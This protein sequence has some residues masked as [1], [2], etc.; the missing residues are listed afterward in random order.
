MLT[1]KELG[2][3]FGVSRERVRQLEVNIK[4]KLV[5]YFRTLS[6]TAKARAKV[7]A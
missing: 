6:K 1:L 5:T 3:E 7:A 2:R 4:R